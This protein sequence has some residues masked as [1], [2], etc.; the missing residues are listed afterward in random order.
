MS[1]FLRYPSC[2]MFE[3]DG[4]KSKVYCQNLCL[5]SKLFLVSQGCH[6]PALLSPFLSDASSAMEVALLLLKRCLLS[7]LLVLMDWVCLH[8]YGLDCA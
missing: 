6:L 4:K 5:L 7:L 8:G 3:V 2:S 1:P